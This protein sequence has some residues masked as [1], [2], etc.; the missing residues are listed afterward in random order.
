NKLRLLALLQFTVPGAPT[1]YYGDEAGLT[2]G[3]DPDDRRTYPW[4]HEDQALIDYYRTLAAL[5]H[6]TLALRSGHWR[7]LS[8][9]PGGDTDASARKDGASIA[10][11]AFNRGT[12]DQRLTLQLGDLAA[13]GTVLKDALTNGTPYTVQG[14]Q[15]TVQ[16][17]A[18]WGALL[19][20]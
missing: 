13:D 4:G 2:G 7:T 17:G 20:P 11:V 15:I 18:K 1:I 9:P 10:V 16:V 5:R 14:G 3:R 6:K 8:A 12:S 19:T